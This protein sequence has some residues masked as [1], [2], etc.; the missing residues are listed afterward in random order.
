MEGRNL[1]LFAP[2]NKIRKKNR[3]FADSSSALLRHLAFVERDRNDPFCF[4]SF[5]FFY[6]EISTNSRKKF[7]TVFWRHRSWK[8]KNAS[9]LSQGTIHIIITHRIRVIILRKDIHWFRNNDFSTFS[10]FYV[11]LDFTVFKYSWFT[12]STWI[13]TTDL[14]SASLTS[15]NTAICGRD[16]AKW[17]W[18]LCRFPLTYLFNSTMF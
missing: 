5:F 11:L 18:L 1:E 17:I 13:C 15:R 14:L 6:Q 2:S 16:D 7:C 9:S 3:I 8:E 12:P 4:V 10:Y